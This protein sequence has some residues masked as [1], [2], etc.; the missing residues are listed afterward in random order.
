VKALIEAELAA[1]RE[2][3]GLIEISGTDAA[4][5]AYAAQAITMIL[6]ELATN[7]AKYGALSTPEGRLSISL[8]RIGDDMTIDWVEHVPHRISQEPEPGFGSRL[9]A[10]LAEQQLDGSIVQNWNT[11][12]LSARLTVPGVG[13][14]SPP[15]FESLRRD[16]PVD[17][18]RNLTDRAILLV[19]D[20]ALVSMALEQALKDAG[21]RVRAFRTV[22]EALSSVR[23]A[24]PELAVLDVNIRGVPITPVATELERLSVPFV[25]VTGY[26]D[27]LSELPH[28]AIV[29]KPCPPIAVRAALQRLVDAA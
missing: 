6:H 9:I 24:P 17:A 16:G 28:G 14:L 19:E 15:S 23:K 25:Y 20:D 22:D 8:D 4:A 29:R 7:A 11:N 5:P 21:G 27:D 18:H 12:G 10:T 26:G 1:H 13:D 2:Q 3:P